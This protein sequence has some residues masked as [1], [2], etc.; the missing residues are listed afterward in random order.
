MN[1][2]N[3]CDARSLSICYR[4]FKCPGHTELHAFNVCRPCSKRGHWCFNH[5]HSL[6]KL[7]VD[8]RGKPQKLGFLSLVRCQPG[9]LTYVEKLDSAT[10]N[11]LPVLNLHLPIEK[12]KSSLHDSPAVL[13]HTRPLLAIPSGKHQILIADLEHNTCSSWLLSSRLP[14]CK[15]LELGSQKACTHTNCRRCPRSMCQSPL[16][17]V[18]ALYICSQCIR[19]SKAI[20]RLGSR[21]H[22]A[23]ISSTIVPSF[24]PD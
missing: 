19:S 14:Y 24:N 20:E 15:Y 4:C 8:S 3:T 1:Q 7:K 21:A 18:R 23:S 11:F 17:A 12:T 10:G 9:L 16:L 6:T 5:D 13:H 2:C 22:I